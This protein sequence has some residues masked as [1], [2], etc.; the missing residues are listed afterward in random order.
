[1]MRP[2]VIDAEF[3]EDDG[4]QLVERDPVEATARDVRTASDAIG[5]LVERGR[6]ILRGLSRHVGAEHRPILPR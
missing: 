6:G 4:P 5:R 3:V 1:M 2:E